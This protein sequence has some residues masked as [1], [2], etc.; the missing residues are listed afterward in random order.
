MRVLLVEDE[1]TAAS[2][3]AKSTDLLRRLP[4]FRLELGFQPLEAAAVIDR[5]LEQT[6]S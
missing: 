2:V 6:R 3:L 1:P 4:S 5:F